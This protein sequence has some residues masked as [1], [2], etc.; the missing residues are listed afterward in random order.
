MISVYG[1]KMLYFL[2]ITHMSLFMVCFI[3]IK[4]HSTNID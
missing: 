2:K 1:D 3:V 4:G